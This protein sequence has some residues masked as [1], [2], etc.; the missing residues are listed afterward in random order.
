MAIQFRL[1]YWRVGVGRR[2][3]IEAGRPD[4]KR[5]SKSSNNEMLVG[6]YSG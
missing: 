3:R 2:S 1:G 4:V 6:E 5:P